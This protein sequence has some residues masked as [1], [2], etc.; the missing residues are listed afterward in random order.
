MPIRSS[1]QV[2]TNGINS[3]VQVPN[4]AIMWNSNSRVWDIVGNEVL[5]KSKITYD[6]KFNQWHHGPEMSMNDIIY[7]VYF[8][9]EWGSER[10][11]NDRT[12]KFCQSLT[13]M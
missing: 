6:L 1:W 10:T 3:S 4:D 5:A 11:E 8:L 12:C 7:S 9:S 13:S 2:E